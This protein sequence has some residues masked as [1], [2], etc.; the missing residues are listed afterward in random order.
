[1]QYLFEGLEPP[2]RR[3]HHYP[4]T[5]VEAVEALGRDI[6]DTDKAHIRDLAKHNELKKLH[7]GFETFVINEFGLHDGNDA[8]IANTGESLAEEAALVIIAKFAET[9]L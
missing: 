6:N 4:K 1:M 9:L 5:V 2:K 7:H 3:R 8:L